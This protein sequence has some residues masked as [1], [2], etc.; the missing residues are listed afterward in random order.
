METNGSINRAHQHHQIPP[1]HGAHLHHHQ[2][3]VSH[4]GG[5]TTTINGVVVD[6]PNQQPVIV[7]GIANGGGG[8]RKV[9]RE[10]SLRGGTSGDALNALTV[11]K[12]RTRAMQAVEYYNSS[13]LSPGVVGGAVASNNNNNNGNYKT[14]G[15]V[16]DSPSAAKEQQQPRKQLGKNISSPLNSLHLSTAAATKTARSVT[17]VNM[18]QTQQDVL[19][20]QPLTRNG[21]SY[22]RGGQTQ[23]PQPQQSHRF[24]HPDLRSSYSERIASGNGNRGHQV[25][26]PFPAQ[27]TGRIGPPAPPASSNVYKSNSSLDLDHEVDMVHEAIHQQQAQHLFQKAPQQQQQQYGSSHYHHMQ[28]QQQQQQQHRREF[29]SHGSIDVITRQELHHQHVFPDIRS[30]DSSSIEP[31]SGGGVVTVGNGGGQVTMSTLQRKAAAAAAAAAAATTAEETQNFHNATTSG[32]G[33]GSVISGSSLEETSPKQ[34][35]KS[36]FFSTK[37]KSSNGGGG[38]GGGQKSLFKKFRSTS[39]KEEHN[40]HHVNA[41][42]GVLNGV[43]ASDVSNAASS[44]SGFGEDRM[45]EDR[46]RRRFFYHFDTGSVCAS[47]S[48]SSQHKTLERRNTT[49]GASAACAALRG[50][51]GGGGDATASAAEKDLGDNISNDLVL[52]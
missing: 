15:D 35:K 25:Q 22:S 21:P 14:L 20:K 9:R 29:G 6:N 16:Y 52:R 44:S 23:Q 45:V 7:G 36:S 37:D 12:A 50:T 11:E 34:K 42:N 18:A 49:T 27:H 28:Q 17:S 39:S 5:S 8:G 38:G 2:Q 46:H 19:F 24:G 10:Q 51:D 41:P 43:G 47:L 30:Y 1:H 13:V 40:V 33:G 4:N 48:V 31:L 3:R 32:G 26:R